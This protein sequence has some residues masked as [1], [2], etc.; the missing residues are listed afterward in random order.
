MKCPHNNENFKY[1]KGYSTPTMKKEANGSRLKG[2]ELVKAIKEAQKDPEFMREINK[3][4][5]ATT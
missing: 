4:I 3:F 1:R 5:D 2:A